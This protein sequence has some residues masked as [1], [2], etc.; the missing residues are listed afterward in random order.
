MSTARFTVPLA[1]PR[2]GGRLEGEATDALLVCAPCGLAR[3][4]LPAGRILALRFA[5]P[6]GGA[7]S[8]LPAIPFYRFGALRAA[9]R[10]LAPEG[11]AAALRLRQLAAGWVMAVRIRR[12]QDHGDAGLEYTRRP[13]RLEPGPPVAALGVAR[14]RVDAE[15]VLRA[16]L[17]RIASEASPPGSF[18][19]DLEPGEPEIL[20]VPALEDGSHVK[21]PHCPIR[22]PA[23]AVEGLG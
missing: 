7:A 20:C 21:L 14:S 2:C 3:E 5:S 8:R 6:P 12:F 9:A 16:S 13:P 19:L 11:E 1:C 18:A 17:W 23:G 22:Y 10:A 4:A 15:A